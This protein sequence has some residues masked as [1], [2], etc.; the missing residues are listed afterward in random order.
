MAFEPHFL[1]NVADI[2]PG[3]SITVS[4]PSG[5]EIALFNIDGS[6][7]ALENACPHMGGPLSEGEIDNGCVTCPWH[8]WQFNIKN[9]TNTTGLGDDAIAIKILL[10]DGKVYLDEPL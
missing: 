2:L 10:K 6:I 4:L 7:H 1:A 9:G 3:Q 8:G 5:K